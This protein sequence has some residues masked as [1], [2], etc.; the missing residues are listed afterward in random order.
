MN[1][2]FSLYKEWDQLSSFDNQAST[3]RQYRNIVNENMNKDFFVPKKIYVY[4]FLI[5]FGTNTGTQ[6]L[7]L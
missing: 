2:M 1:K 6:T 7:W 5:K 4:H 3:V